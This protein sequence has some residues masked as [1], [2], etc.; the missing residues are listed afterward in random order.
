M[1]RVLEALEANDWAAAPAFLDRGEF[2]ED[3]EE[4]GSD[5][6]EFAGSL[7]EGDDD[8]DDMN[9]GI[10][11]DDLAE[12]RKAI[13]NAEQGESRGTKSTEPT[14]KSTEGEKGQDTEAEASTGKKSEETAGTGPDEEDDGDLGEDDLQKLEGMMRKLQA[15][16]DMS[17]GLPEDQRRRIAA[18]AVGEVMRDL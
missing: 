16:R 6:G 14:A 18:R 8:L 4:A 5:F 15:V 2:G 1:P 13:W 11:K 3:D 9:F 12:L 7:G 17:A 10:G